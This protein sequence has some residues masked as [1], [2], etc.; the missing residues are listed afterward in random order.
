MPADRLPEL[1]A[2]IIDVY[3]HR[4]DAWVTSLASLRLSPAASGRGGRGAYR[5]L[6]LAG[7]PS[8][9]PVGQQVDLGEEDGVATISSQDGYIHAPSLQHAATAAVLRSG[10]LAHPGDT[11]FAVNLSSRR[12]RTARWLLGGVRQ[13]QSLGSLLG[14]RF[15]RALH[16]AD[17]DTE[18]PTYRQHVPGADG[19]RADRPPDA[20]ADL[21]SHSTEAIAARNV[22]DGMALVRAGPDALKIT[23]KPSAVAPILAD[24]ADALDAV[25]DLVLAESVYHL[26]G[27]Q[28]PACRAGRRH[29][30]PGRGR[31]GHVLLAAHPAPG[32]GR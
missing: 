32:P 17:L 7:G 26:V 9:A 8:P 5:R 12:A 29:A 21:W 15:E 13:G 18:I 16:D 19:D 23:A 14:Y 10:F 25:G 2:E 6:R 11:T 24:L 31:P 22:V 20:N 27:R 4:L 3:T 30:G 1:L 28:P